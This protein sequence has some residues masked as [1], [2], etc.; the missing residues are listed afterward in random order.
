M[1]Y[2]D[3]PI[4]MSQLRPLI[5]IFVAGLA[6]WALFFWWTPTWAMGTLAV[7]LGIGVSIALGGEY[8][9]MAERRMAANELKARAELQEQIDQAGAMVAPDK[10]EAPDNAGKS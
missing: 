10:V 8:K 5:W 2:T 7:L 1:R 9:R 4:D 3:T 6:A